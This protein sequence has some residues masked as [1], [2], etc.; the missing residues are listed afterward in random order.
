MNAQDKI[1]LADMNIQKNDIVEILEDM[2]EPTDEWG[3]C[4]L[5][6]WKYGNNV[7]VNGIDEASDAILELINKRINYEK[8]N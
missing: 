4:K 5:A 8:T 2:L 3:G 7:L 1:I 6:S